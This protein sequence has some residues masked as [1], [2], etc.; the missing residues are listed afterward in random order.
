MAASIDARCGRL[1]NYLTLPAI[2][3]SIPLG[4]WLY[5]S[6]AFLGVAIAAGPLFLIALFGEIGMGDVKLSIALGAILGPQGA[7]MMLLLTT[8]SILSVGLI[9]RR[10]L[11]VGGP[12]LAL[13]TAACLP[14]FSH[15]NLQF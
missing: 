3:L 8:I 7:Y 6:Q 11:I 9:E 13:S 14:F 10:R 4:F 15:S 2:L 1:P 12:Y 5:G